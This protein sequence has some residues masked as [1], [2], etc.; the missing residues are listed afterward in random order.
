MNIVAAL[1][2]AKELN[3]DMNK[4]I[5]TALN[6]KGLSHRLQFVAEK[7]GVTYYND[8]IST[9]PQA[10][11]AALSALKNVS[12]LILGGMDRGIDYTMIG[13]VVKIYKVKNI[14]FVGKAGRR[15]YEEMTKQNLTFNAFVSDSYPDIV[16]WC[17]QTAE[18]N[19][20]VLLSPAASSYDMFKN[21]EY[22]GQCFSDLVL[23]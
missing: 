9:I 6:F 18:K 11:M 21:F 10:T 19:S 7:D 1:K 12:T 2:I 16:A 3:L 14:A 5:E 23:K 20:I 4:A 17:K 8:S 22:R 13:D 15:M